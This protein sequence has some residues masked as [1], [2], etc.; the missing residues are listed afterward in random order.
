MPARRANRAFLGKDDGDRLA[1]D[2]GMRLHF[3]ERGRRSDL[4]AP[5]PERAVTEL[6]ARFIQFVRD[7]APAQLLILEERLHFLALLRKRFVFAAN[8]ELFQPAQRN[9]AA[10]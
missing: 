3:H 4:G 10:Y 2:K 9:G 7:T 5:R 1:L 8:L 6:P